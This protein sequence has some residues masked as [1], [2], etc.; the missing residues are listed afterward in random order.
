[1]H[2]V[3]V[4][5]CNYLTKVFVAFDVLAAFFDCPGE[6]LFINITHRKQLAGSID[7]LYVPHPHAA[8]FR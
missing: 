8:R 7:A 6:M 1:M 2:D 4:L 5:P 3:D